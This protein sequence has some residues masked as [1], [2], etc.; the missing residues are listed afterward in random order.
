MKN[1]SKVMCG[2]G[3]GLRRFKQLPDLTMCGL[4]VGVALQKQLGRRKRRGTIEKPK[5]HNA[6]GAS[7]ICSVDPE[8]MASTEK[9]SKREATFGDSC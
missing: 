1:L 5:I 9:P 6:R 4:K 2:P 7:G 8:D 3:G